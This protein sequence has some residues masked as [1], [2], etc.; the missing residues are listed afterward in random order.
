V[1]K[2]KALKRTLLVV[3][4]FLLVIILV[5]GGYVG[6]V[7]LSYY[8]IPD[9]LKLSVD[10]VGVNGA[11]A[12]QKVHVGQQYTAMT[13]NIG[14]GAYN[15]PF[16][17]FMDQGYRA[18]G[19][20]TQG[21]QSRVANEQTEV[22]DTNGAAAHAFAADPDFAL[23]QEVDVS[24]DRSANVDQK[25][26]ITSAAEQDLKA[27]PG[28]A[29]KVD[30]LD[31]VYATNFHTPY[32]QYPVLNPIGTTRDSGILT[33]SQFQIDQATRVSLPVTSSWPAM[34]FDYDRCLQV[35]RLPVVGADGQPSAHQLVLINLHLSAYDSG[36]VI[37][38]QQMKVLSGILQQEYNAGNWVIVGGD[39][40]Q[41]LGD[42]Y[43]KFKNQMQV[44]DWIQPFDAAKIPAHFSMVYADN[45]E[46]QPTNRDDSVP[47]VDGYNYQTT[48]DGFIVS[49]NVQAATHIINTDY[50]VSDHNPVQLTFALK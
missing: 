41:A 40:N 25:A 26:L 23:F 44:P 16:S 4:T 10:A 13:Y 11:A 28:V 1:V 46:T 24:G 8:R 49:D 5:V 21:T 45:F 12:T 14:F 50:D 43:S 27:L 15:H 29:G 36:G 19:T 18:D 33:Y 47:Y 39:F 20:P 2:H 17:F 34:Y 9:N 48:I 31:S 37:R 32:F 42:S 30:G 3:L 38:D 7:A 35:M 22:D 6:Y